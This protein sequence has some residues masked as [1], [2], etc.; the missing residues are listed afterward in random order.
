M[1]KGEEDKL[2]PVNGKA[3]RWMDKQTNTQTHKQTDGW[4][5]T[6]TDRWINKADKHTNRQMDG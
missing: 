6:Q 1:A 3:D 4:T 2:L 5:N